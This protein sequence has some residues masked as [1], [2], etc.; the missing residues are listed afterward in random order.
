M[1]ALAAY[2]NTDWII[3]GDTH[4]P[5]QT[6]AAIWGG[7]MVAQNTSAHAVAAADAATQI[8][9]Y[10]VAL[11]DSAA[12]TVAGNKNVKLA[13]GVFRLGGAT[14]VAAD[15][16]KVHYVTDDQTFGRAKGTN[17]IKA[18]I[19]VLRE[20][21]SAGLLLIPTKKPAGLGITDADADGT[22]GAPEAALLNKVRDYVNDYLI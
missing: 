12:A 7:G 17:A 11:R 6:N 2:R 14:L 1:V 19:M 4:E 3:P 21:A 20:S 18:G 5:P 13:I 10:G 22:Y 9:V 16:G 8:G 15:T